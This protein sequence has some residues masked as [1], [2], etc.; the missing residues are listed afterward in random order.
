MTCQ[1]ARAATGVAGLTSQGIYFGDV[2]ANAHF[3]P[4]CDDGPNMRVA[5]MFY[6]RSS[7]LDAV[8]GGGGPRRW[9]CMGARNI[10]CVM[11][12]LELG[13]VPVQ[14]GP[15]LRSQALENVKALVVLNRSCDFLM[16]NT[17]AS[18]EPQAPA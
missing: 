1:G 11:T 16:V 13:H 2:M 17:N 8:G 4:K 5:D 3:C 12:H 18:D 14:D 7:G 15:S 10:S 9:G 6:L